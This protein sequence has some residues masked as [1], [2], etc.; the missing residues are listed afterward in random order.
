MAF[1]SICAAE[2]SRS[3]SADSSFW[4]ALKV[5]THTH[6]HTCSHTPREVDANVGFPAVDLSE[7]E[8]CDVTPDFQRLSEHTPDLLLAHLPGEPH[9][10]AREQYRFYKTHAACTVAEQDH[11]NLSPPSNLIC[12]QLRALS[13]SKKIHLL[14]RHSGIRTTRGWYNQVDVAKGG[15]TLV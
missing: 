14:G 1:W 12:S 13:I 4:T 9:D 8:R 15:R 10:P 11:Q 2:R 7:G 5:F 6:K 3:V